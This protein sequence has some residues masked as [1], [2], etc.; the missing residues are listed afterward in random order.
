MTWEINCD[1]GE[2]FALYRLG[3]D[4]AIMPWIT[5]ANVACG[6]H[7][8]DPMVMRRTVQLARRFGVRVGAHPS[9]PDREGFGRRVMAL[10]PDEIANAVLYQV[11]ALQGFLAA[12]G[13]ALSHVKPHGALYGMA[14][15]DEAVATAIAEAAAVFGVPL[16]GLAGTAHEAACRRAGTAFVG[17]FYADLDYDCDGQL[18]ITREH[19]AVEPQAAARR[20]LRALTEGTVTAVDGSEVAVRATTVCVHS[21]TPAAVAVA[22]AVSETLARVAP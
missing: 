15:R 9:L 21:D 3:D 17:E 12:E 14:A 2:S 4:E 5:A 20:V 11:G 18:L 6:V 13:M 7:A 10:R 1:L 16:Y 22:R 8:G 19:A